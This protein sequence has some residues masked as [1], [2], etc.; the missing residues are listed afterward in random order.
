M[1]LPVR[2]TMI[3]DEDCVKDTST[4]TDALLNAK[5]NVADVYTDSIDAAIANFVELTDL[6]VTTAVNGNGSLSY[7]NATG[8]FT[9]AGADLSTL[10]PATVLTTPF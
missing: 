6:S 9:F 10:A 1:R 3:S 4:Q 8:Q 2:S 5:A 7:N